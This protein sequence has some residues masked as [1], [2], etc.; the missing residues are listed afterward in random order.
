MMDGWMDVFSLDQ[1]VTAFFTII[2]YTS[3]HLVFNA[4]KG[5]LVKSEDNA[6]VP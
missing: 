3:M 2:A 6:D 1:P 4:L 5:A